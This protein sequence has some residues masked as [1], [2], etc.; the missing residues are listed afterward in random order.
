MWH[1][2]WQR[3]LLSASSLIAADVAYLPCTYMITELLL[4]SQARMATQLRDL[5]SL[6]LDSADARAE[7][8]QA[9]GD[10]TRAAQV[11]QAESLQSVQSSLLRCAP[12]QS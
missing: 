9:A 1:L 6:H 12:V 11:A 10:A 2:Q 5:E 4:V 3:Q 8:M 7:A